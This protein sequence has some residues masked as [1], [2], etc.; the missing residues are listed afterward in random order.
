MMQRFWAAL[1]CAAVLALAVVRPGVA[2]EP[3]GPQTYALII[4]VSNTKDPQIQKRE[5]AEDDARALYQLLANGKHLRTA[6]A[7]VRLLLGS[8]DGKTAQEAT[9]ANILKGLAWLRDNAKP[10]DSV[11]LAYF[12]T[13]GPVG[14]GGQR[15]CYFAADSTV[16]GRASD[17]VSA[18]EIGDEFAKIKS[19]RLA[20]F[21]DVNFKSITADPPLDVRLGENPYGE[22]L[23]E[24]DSPEHN[25]LPGRVLFLATN[26]LSTGIDLKE[27]KHSLFGQ[28]LLDGLAGAA[29]K[30][31]TKADGVVTTRELASYMEAEAPK[32]WKQFAAQE[33]RPTPFV[34]GAEQNRFVLVE[35]PEEKARIEKQVEALGRLL[36][37]E[38]ALVREGKE[39]LERMP[40]TEAKRAL[41]QNYLDLIEG[42][43]DREAFKSQRTKRLAEMKLAEGRD[44]RFAEKV[45]EAVHRV[46]AEY[47][48]EGEHIKPQTLV[49]NAIT[50]LYRRLDEEPSKE[51]KDKLAG[52]KNMSNRELQ[53]LLAEAR[54]QLGQREDLDDHKD[55]DIALQRMLSKLD[56]Y[57]TYIGPAD[58]A[59][60]EIDLKAEYTGIGAQIRKDPVTDWVRIVTPLRGGPAYNSGKIQADDLIVKIIRDEDSEGKPITDTKEKEIDT[61]DLTLTEVVKRLLGARNTRVKLQIRREGRD[62][63]EVVE[64]VRGPVKQETVVGF[65][66]KAN[67]EWDY[68]I[69]NK[70]KIGYIR[71]T[72]FA[73]ATAAD[74]E[75]VLESLQD[76]GIKGLILDLRFN[77]GGLLRAA[78]Q[79][80]DMFLDSR[81][82]VQIR[83]PRLNLAQAIPGNTRDVLSQKV[84]MVVLVNGSSASA[85]EILAACL[86]DHGRALIGGERSFGKG[87]VQNVLDFDGGDLKLTT[88]GFFSPKGKNLNK[89]SPPA[90]KPDEWGVKPD[91]DVKLE[92]PKGEEDALAEYLHDQEVIKKDK[93]P[94]DKPFEDRQLKKALEFLQRG[95]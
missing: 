84:P 91:E 8:P 66:R 67:D 80:C 93:K 27:K 76:Q 70:N 64:I 24:D 73:Q 83:K 78:T 49:S 92:L 35:N 37:D 28:L 31:G 55:I 11:I 3:R 74:L 57:S 19:Q 23:G 42:K 26:G 68:M 46:E 17:A 2:E 39:L 10:D 88:A 4:G 62:Q 75:R 72:S 85:S 95:K 29:D 25:P 21:L 14:E 86:Q 60:F 44:T 54:R 82:L 1:L 40:P 79:I 30:E 51:L 61:K 20:V 59:R 52:I 63:D 9:R 87:S 32:L 69:D 15:R 16:K 53:S 58:K 43:L 90:D 48:S 22:F 18:N 5:F 36:K 34:I 56:P 71:L 41:R 89:L 33:K 47:V 6:P 81:A 94:S 50:G 45:M 7:N 12:G 38:A 77:P 13:G 65:R